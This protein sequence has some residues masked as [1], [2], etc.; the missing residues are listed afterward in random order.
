MAV[1][2]FCGKSGCDRFFVDHLKNSKK[3][4]IPKILT[5]GKSYENGFTEKHDG[6][7]DCAKSGFN[8][9]FMHRLQIL[10]TIPNIFALGKLYNLGF[11]KTI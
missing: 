6:H 4:I 2:N 8:R 5:L 10:L 11:A 7:K 3:L 9:F 1:I